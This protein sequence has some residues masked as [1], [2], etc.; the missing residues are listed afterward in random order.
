LIGHRENV[1]WTADVLKK[2]HWID[3]FTRIVFVEFTT[4]NPNTNLFTTSLITFEMPSTGVILTRVQIYTFRLFSYLGGFGIFVILCELC[5][6]AC[7]IYF[8]GLEMKQIKRDGR[9]HFKS[10]WNSLQFVTLLTSVTCV[11]MYLLRHAMTSVAVDKIKKLKGLPPFIHFLNSH[12]LIFKINPFD[13]LFYA[14]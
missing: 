12:M 8:I 7:V 6:L 10:F 9:Q 14:F 2:K 13:I 4:Y 5:A 11:I 1:I 3:K